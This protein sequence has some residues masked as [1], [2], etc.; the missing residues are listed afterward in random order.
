MSQHQNE[1]NM[2][3]VRES[4][5]RL[6]PSQSQR[7]M[8]PNVNRGLLEQSAS[9]HSLHTIQQKEQQGVL[10]KSNE[11][12]D[13]S[14][15]K[16]A[17]S[18]LYQLL[19]KTTE[20]IETQKNAQNVRNSKTQLRR[21]ATSMDRRS[22]TSHIKRVQTQVDSIVKQINQFTTTYQHDQAQ[23]AQDFTE[24]IKEMQKLLHFKL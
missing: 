14:K 2:A 11:S 6:S 8:I 4:L 3:E 10:H 12:F 17:E 1:E 19:K 21:T 5:M 18:K 22:N 13:A 15:V 16:N 23:D 7:N 20:S 24:T 9:R